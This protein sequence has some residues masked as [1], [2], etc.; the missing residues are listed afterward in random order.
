MRLRTNRI[1]GTGSLECHRT[2]P[3]PHPQPVLAWWPVQTIPHDCQKRKHGRRR[4]ESTYLC[5]LLL[6][7]GE[8]SQGKPEIQI[9]THRNRWTESEREKLVIE[10][11][12]EW[13]EMCCCQKVR[14]MSKTRGEARGGQE[15]IEFSINMGDAQMDEWKSISAIRFESC[16]WI[17]YFGTDFQQQHVASYAWSFFQDFNFF[18]PPSA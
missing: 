17:A 13:N 8:K 7:F 16:N 2:E 14:S 15:Q 18:M 3:S 6:S 9:N 1:F 4:D 12:L 10:A 11:N 5:F